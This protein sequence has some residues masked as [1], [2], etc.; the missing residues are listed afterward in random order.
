V[1][2]KDTHTP[3]RLFR[4]PDEEYDPALAK[5]RA[6]GTTLTAIVRQ[7]LRDYVEED[8]E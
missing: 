5:A 6:N 4:V 8:D 2:P 3:G 1:T 7:G